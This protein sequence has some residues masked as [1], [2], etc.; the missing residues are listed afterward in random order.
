M[1]LK[2]IS[3]S[4]KQILQITA[5]RDDIPELDETYTVTLLDPDIFGDLSNVNATASITILANQ[6]PYGFLEIFPIDRYTI[7][8]V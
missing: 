5:V 1:Y 3:I 7:Y 4:N 2:M 6:N 8:H